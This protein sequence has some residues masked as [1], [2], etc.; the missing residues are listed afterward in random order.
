MITRW[1]M[2][3]ILAGSAASVPAQDGPAPDRINVRDLGAVGDG[4]TDDTQAFLAAVTRG[5]ETQRHVYVPRGRY[6]ISQPIVLENIAL[7]G[8][9]GG[10]WP[11]DVDALP[12]LVP[13]HRD[14]PAIHLLAGGALHHLGIAYEWAAEPETGPPAVL[15]GGIGAFIS[16]VK[17]MYAWDGILADGKSNIG[18]LNVDNVFMVAIRNVG[19]RVTG[20]WDVPALR[21]IEVW[22]LGPVPRGLNEGIGF[23]LG[24]N[25]LI[26]MTDCFAFAMRYGFLLEDKI[27]GCEIEGGTWGVL[28]GCS[29]DFCG[30][31]LALRGNHTVSLT[32]GTF[33]DHAESL[34]VDGEGARVRL[35]GAELKS[36]GAP[37]V[38]VRNCDH[39]VITGCSLLRPMESFAAPAAVLDGGR[40]ILSDNHIESF[41]PGV[42]IGPAVRSAVVRGNLID[43]HGHE[44]ILDQHG[45]AGKVLVEGNL[46]P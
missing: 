5:K 14:G 4:K 18:R 23:H 42:E 39:T 11:A 12:T 31:G 46:T 41:G 35:T 25:D 22:N 8:P 30:T 32:G 37:A 10:A 38:V 16:H 24:K 20:T 45:E 7:T 19:V 9:G 34:V 6:V 43:P 1:I 26:R 3:G 17:I 36:N 28:T 44:A 40:V 29:T 2:V 27:E 13:T 33:W 21:N 15:I